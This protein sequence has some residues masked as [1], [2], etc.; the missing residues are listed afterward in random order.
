[1]PSSRVDST[2]SLLRKRLRQILR[3]IPAGAKRK[4]AHK[5]AA[6]LVRN[7]VFKT[8]QAILMYASLP[9]EVPTRP[10]LRKALALGKKV[11]LPK[12]SRQGKYLEIY[13]V[14]DPAA[15]LTKGMFGIWEPRAIPSRKGKPAE[16]DLVIV[17]GLGFD[18]KGRRLGHGGGYFDRFLKRATGAVKIGLAFREQVVKKIPTG[19]N[20]VRVD[21][22]LTD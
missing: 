3:A 7:T 21:R 12:V 2:K 19:P 20:D 10:L 11:Y 18:R 9:E 4:K 22:V 16:L 17:P 8:S 14:T 15:D 13:R 6:K 1:M 5:I